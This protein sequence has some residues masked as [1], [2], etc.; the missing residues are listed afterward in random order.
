MDF[1]F[2]IFLNLEWYYKFWSEKKFL[3]CFSLNINTRAQNF[4]CKTWNDSTWK[5]LCLLKIQGVLTL[6]GKNR[7]SNIKSN[8]LFHQ[9]ASVF[10][11]QFSLFLFANHSR[12]GFTWADGFVLTAF[13]HHLCF[14]LI[15]W[16]Q[17]QSSHC[18]FCSVLFLFSSLSYSIHSFFSHSLIT[19]NCW[20]EPTTAL[21][22]CL[23]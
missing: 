12:Y 4:F 5:L 16:P 21:D 7:T 3:F 8:R 23:C 17:S 18:H 19:W 13:G 11:L 22:T 9:E 10:F 20:S 1:F 2:I 6:I 15:S 14:L